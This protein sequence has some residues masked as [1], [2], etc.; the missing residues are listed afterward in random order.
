MPQLWID[1]SPYPTSKGVLQGRLEFFVAQ[2]V[3]VQNLNNIYCAAL[4]LVVAGLNAFTTVA[5]P[6]L[7]MLYFGLLRL[8]QCPGVTVWFMVKSSMFIM[9]FVLINLGVAFFRRNHFDTQYSFQTKLDAEIS[10]S[11]EADRIL[12][13]CLKNNIA[14]AAG[15]LDIVI[16]DAGKGKAT[17]LGLLR[18]AREALQRGMES[19][20]SRKTFTKLCAGTCEPDLAPVHLPAFARSLA[21]GR[22][23]QVSAPDVWV[24][25]DW[26]LCA[27]V[28]DNAISNALRHGDPADPDVRLT[29]AHEAALADPL[30]I[31]L[32]FRVT[33]RA[34]PRLSPQM[35]N[36]MGE[37]SVTVAGMKHISAGAAAQGMAHRLEWEG[38]LVVFTAT[39][40]VALAPQAHA[41]DVRP[42]RAPHLP[43]GL[44]YVFVDDSESQR[45]LMEHAIATHLDPSVLRVFGESVAE[46]QEFPGAAMGA[47]IAILDQNIDLEGAEYKGTDLVAELLARGFRGLLCIRSANTSEAE[48]QRYLQ[49]GAHCVLGK[50]L[51]RSE[52]LE[53]LTLA[54][55]EAVLKTDTDTG[56]ASVHSERLITGSPTQEVSSSIPAT[57]SAQL[58]TSLSSEP[59]L[60]A[61]SSSITHSLS[62]W[63]S[64]PALPHPSYAGH[65]PVPA[66]PSEELLH[67]MTSAS[68]AV[69]IPGLQADLRGSPRLCRRQEA[70]S[71]EALVDVGLLE[72]MPG[73]T[74]SVPR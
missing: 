71:S 72:L 56:T 66:S 1:I 26:T 28:L 42:S 2:N 61:S 3:M 16:A 24:T 18:A 27:L 10:A 7:P 48:V 11:T 64:G 54:Y 39:M 6:L 8:L 32:Q 46:L 49:S 52:M 74:S 36:A 37:G 23:V 57:S 68:S 4:I 45:R 65:P 50:E 58:P 51:R 34:D 12:N 31:A 5:I 9:I 40:E 70:T 38:P 67:P 35:N 62:L 20:R 15:N 13:H 55:H 69:S 47:D 63:S 33:N 14:D 53:Q 60:N 21:E 22:Q 43:P 30:R 41:T 29:I 44:S 17:R 25:L 19:C 59:R 73:A